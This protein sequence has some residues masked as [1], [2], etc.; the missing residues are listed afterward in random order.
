MSREYAEE[1]SVEPQQSVISLQN[2]MM[3]IHKL[4]FIL[5]TTNK[6]VVLK[7]DFHDTR[8]RQKAMKTAGVDSV[9]L[10][11]KE[12]K[13]RVTGDIDLVV[14]VKKLRKICYTELVSVGAAAKEPKEKEETKKKKEESKKKD[15]QVMKMPIYPL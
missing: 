13:L 14:A 1:R 5:Q 11:T 12:N 3:N 7:L 10:D 4:S 9:A 8:C 2:Q 6:V 15:E